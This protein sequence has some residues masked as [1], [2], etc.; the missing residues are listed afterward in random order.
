MKLAGKPSPH[1]S[2]H[3]VAGRDSGCAGTNA[4]DAGEAWSYVGASLMR[5]TN[6][7]VLPAS[8]GAPHL[9]GVRSP[10]ERPGATACLNQREVQPRCAQFGRSQDASIS[11]AGAASVYG[12]SC[13]RL[14]RRPGGANGLVQASMCAWGI[15]L[16]SAEETTG[17]QRSALAAGYRS[18]GIQ[19]RFARALLELLSYSWMYPDVYV[20]R[21]RLF[22]MAGARIHVGQSNMSRF[23]ITLPGSSLAVQFLLLRVCNSLEFRPSCLALRFKVWTSRSVGLLLNVPS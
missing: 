22:C 9:F 12:V 3:S 14:V 23:P 1:T 8:P 16:Q 6:G 13:R 18:N 10:R 17:C 4:G 2:G 20:R 15:N 7:P 11:I 21:R 5:P 19:K